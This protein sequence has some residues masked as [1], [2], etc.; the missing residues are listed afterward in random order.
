MCGPEQGQ[1]GSPGRSD[2]RA[3]SAPSPPQTLA[4]PQF[5]TA[6]PGEGEA[7]TLGQELQ[8]KGLDMWFWEKGNVCRPGFSSGWSAWPH[9]ALGGGGFFPTRHQTFCFVFRKGPTREPP[10]LSPSLTDPGGLRG[11]SGSK[12][13]GCPGRLARLNLGPVGAA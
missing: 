8:G 10:G 13:A 6:L 9:S 5:Q 12:E 3:P 1:G 2:V 11:Q 4:R 7:D